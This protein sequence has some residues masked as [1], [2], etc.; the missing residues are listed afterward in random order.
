MRSVAESYVLFVCGKDSIDKNQSLY[1][2]YNTHTQTS[3]CSMNVRRIVLL[4]TNWFN[5]RAAKKCAFSDSNS[6]RKIYNVDEL[7]FGW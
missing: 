7:R 6:L 3:T 1:F 4:R 5:E 2:F